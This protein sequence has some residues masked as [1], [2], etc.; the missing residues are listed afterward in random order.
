MKAA[1][2]FIS[3]P[4]GGA[5]DLVLS[6]V[7]SDAQKEKPLIV[8]LRELG[9][10]G[11]EAKAM[12]LPAHLLPVATRKQFNPFGIFKLAAWLKHHGV[13]IVHSHVY[14]SHVYA[15]LAARWAG[16]PAVIHH[17]KTFNPRRKRRWLIM[18]FLSTLAS[19]HITLSEQTRSDLIQ[20]LHLT[21]GKTHVLPN[22]VDTRLFHPPE[23]RGA[24]RG[25]LGLETPGWLIGGI[26]S[27]SPQKNHEATLE[28]WAGLKKAGIPFSGVIC[29]EGPMREPLSQRMKDLELTSI[30][31]LA[32]NQ[33]PIHPWLQAFDLMVLP[34]SWEGQ[35]M[36]LLQAMA[37]G[38][39]ILA[40]RIEGNIAALGETHPGFFDLNKQGHYLELVKRFCTD[41]SYRESIQNYQ[42]SQWA[43]QTSMGDYILGLEKIYRTMV[44]FR[45]T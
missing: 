38:I 33:R 7:S 10:V 21:P 8:C 24:L 43:T 23:N 39:P 31:R 44:P 15:V 16:L 26:A 2:V 18:R 36:V 40:S 20:V 35:P 4:V 29:G 17:H 3:M 41:S 6:L 11:E 37:C 13:D 12:N 9:I 45:N 1:H 34:S 32:G 14:N 28:M 5:E 42:A 30:A 19:C 27:L 22:C 25:R